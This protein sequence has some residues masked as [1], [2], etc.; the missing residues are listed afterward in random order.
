[1]TTDERNEMLNLYSDLCKDVYGS[2]PRYDYKSL[3]DKEL[4]TSWNEMIIMLEEDNKREALLQKN[5]I[6]AFEASIDKMISIGAEDRETALRWL[7]SAFEDN[8]YC[9]YDLASDFVYHLGFKWTDEGRK[10]IEEIK[11]CCSDEITAKEREYW[12]EEM[13]MQ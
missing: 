3:S 4:Q 11:I 1:M 6:L 9:G 5:S 10:L 7:F 2:R 13:E 12:K 8:M